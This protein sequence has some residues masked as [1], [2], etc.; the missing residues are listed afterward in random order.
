MYKVLIV[1]DEPQIAGFVYKKFQK[2][3][4]AA[5]VLNSGEHVVATVVELVPDIVVLDVMLPIKDGIS[6]ALDIRKFSDVPI[7]ILTAKRADIDRIKGLEAG[8]DDYV[9]KP[10]NAKELVLRAQAILKRC[11][12]VTVSNGLVL[13]VNNHTLQY[14]GGEFVKLTKLEFLLLQLLYNRPGRIFSRTQIFDLAYS[15]NEENSERAVDSHVKNLRKKI[16]SLGISDVVIDSV[17]GEG[18]QFIPPGK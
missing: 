12:A 16:K 13:D 18:F 3:G 17:Y 14:D 6:C 10:F 2:A 5:T 9:C 7:I 4:F 8:V 15:D 1:E 11:K